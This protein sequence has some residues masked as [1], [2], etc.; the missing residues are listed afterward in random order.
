[1]TYSTN[2]IADARGGKPS[3]SRMTR[4]FNC[5]ASFQLNAMENPET[6]AAAE[7]GR[8]LHRVM[9]L[10]VKLGNE[11][12]K[13]EFDALFAA[14]TDEQRQAY[15]TAVKLVNDN[16]LCD[17]RA[18]NGDRMEVFEKRLWAASGLFSG[19]GDAVFI[20]D[21][22]E[23]T[24]VDYK[25]GRG[26]V[27]PA[28]RNYQL[29]A[30]AV[31]V[32]DNYG[33]E[34]IE[35][36]RALIIQPR[37]LD[38]NKRITECIYTKADVD[39]AREAINAACKEAIEYAQPRQKC[40]Y[41]CN[42]CKSAYRCK[43]AQLEIAK[44][45]AIATS[46]PTLAIG[47][48]NVVEMFTKATVVKKLCDE[49]LAAV[50]N[51]IVKNPDHGTALELAAGAKRSKLGD[52]GKIYDAVCSIGITP[53]EFV[54]VCDVGLTKLQSLYFSKRKI[55]NEKQTKKASD[56]EVKDLLESKGLLTYT[57]VAPSLRLKEE[58]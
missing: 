6:S 35:K 3:A 41:W 40:G 39:A 54:E 25:F 19:Q 15:L 4:I 32:A 45:Y 9:E 49:I 55:V 5:P 46:T 28:E 8:M 33:V 48:H 51:F 30:M 36:V 24:I 56:F 17:F 38:K 11:S 42:Y 26:E 18:Y 27:E 47:A 50:K 13:P 1:M 21:D 37:A 58:K 34:Q 57:Q 10:A 16:V 29:A 2:D 22:G 43:T 44:Q 53:E 31:L 20:K 23:A 12:E 52:A 14:L 7:E